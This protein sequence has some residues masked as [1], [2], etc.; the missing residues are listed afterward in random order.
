MLKTFTK[1]LYPFS[2]FLCILT[3][4]FSQGTVI[5]GSVADADTGEPLIGV[6]ILVKGKVLGTITD[7]NGDF[8]LGISDPPPVTLVF[9]IVGY[10]TQDVEIEDENIT[11]LN[12]RLTEKLLSLGQE[13]VVSASRVQESFLQSPVSI[14]KLDILDVRNAAS[15]SFYDEITN[16]KGVD[17]STQSLTHKTINTR[18]FAANGNLR[19]VQLID[20]IDNQAPGL[21]FPVGNIVGISDLDLESAE[22]IPGAASALYGPNALNGILLLT[23]KSPFEYQGVSASARVGMNH[24]D[25]EDDDL[26]AFQKY[27]FRYAR[28][29]NDKFAFKVVVDYTQ[30]IPGIR[31]F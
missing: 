29:I 10:A 24:V 7:V 21:N 27:A 16:I 25:E 5:S 18:G 15:P 9:S 1:K 19:F 14:E 8:R 20:G 2:V 28:A 30:L 6:N 12:V 22:L 11:D 3:E 4:A 26:A 13:I 17:F 31:A 23:S